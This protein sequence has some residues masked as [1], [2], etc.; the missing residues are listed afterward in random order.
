M[1]EFIVSSLKYRPNSFKSVVGQ[2][3]VTKTLK[4]S[5][6]DNKIP[7]A[8]LFCGPRGVGKTSCARIFA[9]EINNFTSEDDLSFNIFELDAASNNKVEDIRDL[10]DKVRIPPQSG[11]YKVYIIDEVHMLSKN[12]ENAFLKTLEEPPQYIVFIL[13]TTEKNKILPTILSRCQIYDFNRISENKISENLR[14][15]CNKEDFK[16]QDE[17]LEIIAKKSDGSLRDSLT[18][19]DRVVN[20]TNKN[21]SLK[22]TSSILNVLDIE[23]YV[24]IVDKI[25]NGFSVEAILSFNVLS[26]KGFNEKE[27]LIGLADHFRNLLVV[28]SSFSEKLISN[29]FGQ[30][31]LLNQSEKISKKEIID[32]IKK[33]EYSIFKYPEIENKKLL[34]EILLMKISFQY[35]ER[36]SEE[37]PISEKKKTELNTLKKVSIYSKEDSKVDEEIYNNEKATKSLLEEKKNQNKN[38]DEDKKNKP[39][40]L[41]EEVS[42]FSLSSLK[43]KKKVTDE[44]KKIEDSIEKKDESIHINNLKEKWN[45]YASNLEKKGKGNFSSLLTLNEPKVDNDSKIIYNLP[46]RSSKKELVEIKE[47]LLFFLKKSLKNDFLELKFEI[48]NEINKEYFLTPIEKYKKLKEINPTIEKFKNDL[49]LDF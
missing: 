49:K 43:I 31:L 22:E 37:T 13:A 42:A 39:I 38:T 4:N 7:S 32:T 44:I 30:E 3:Q 35:E 17:A 8:I 34:V 16:F 33:I 28:K 48:N 10:I 1:S 40:N 18:I 19:L 6:E 41:K 24:K 45:I 21:I 2:E 46:S 36:S 26:D 27:F 14:H 5:I 47:D 11:K 25:I 15:I 20:F 9:R 29:K 12:A 23:T